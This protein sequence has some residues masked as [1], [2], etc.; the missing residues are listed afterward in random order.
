M[1]TFVF[2]LIS[3]SAYPI[4]IGNNASIDTSGHEPDSKFD[5]TLRVLEV[6]VLICLKLIDLTYL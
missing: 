1:I 4:L 5:T 3:N 6:C 2:G